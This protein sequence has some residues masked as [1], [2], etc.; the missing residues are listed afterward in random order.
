[1][2][3][4][5]LKALVLAC[6]FGAVL[7]GV[8][9]LV[10]WLGR[11]R[12]E[13]KAINLRLRMIGEGK[14]HGETL[15]LLRRAESALPQGLPPLLARLGRKFESMLI[16]A[17]VTIPTGRLMIVILTAPVA[18]FFFILLIMIAAG[19]PVAF[20]R[21]LLIATFCAV[22]G[23]ALPLMVL[24][25]KATRTR[26]RMQEQFPVALDVFVRGLRAGHPI[27][28]A[29]DLLTVE[30][31]DP[32][33][34]QFG[35]VVD[36]VTYGAELRDALQSMADRWG[37]DDMRMFVVSL[38]VQ[39]ET[40]G[41]LAEILENLSQVIRERASMMMKVRALSSEG[42]MTAIMLTAL[43]IFA[44]SILFLVNPAFYMDVA[45][46]PAFV[47]GFVGLI[48][49]YIIGFVSM[50]RMVDLKV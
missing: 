44:F 31:P 30:M 24:N 11:S 2:T 4:S 14:T 32:I 26:K 5:S 12:S 8:E 35:I 29:L 7:L 40:G 18:L 27:A 49:L 20:G 47:P 43:P 21:L 28:A 36:E 15:N 41:N 13:S 6:I 22:V 9:A 42:R 33:G 19:I 3:E 37:L 39:N 48:V 38:S 34:S 17:Q 10:S 45:D 50:R 16:A 25:M 23:A 46:D 1:M